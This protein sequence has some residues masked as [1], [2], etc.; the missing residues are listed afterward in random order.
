LCSKRLKYSL[1]ISKLT[2]IGQRLKK[3]KKN[4]N[5]IS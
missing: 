3:K 1:Y 4:V 2:D 5:Y